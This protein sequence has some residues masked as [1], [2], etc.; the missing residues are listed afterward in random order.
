MTARRCRTHVTLALCFGALGGCTNE[1]SPEQEVRSPLPSL[2]TEQVPAGFPAGTIA[3]RAPGDNALTE[4]RARLG[5]RLFYD[6]G[7]SRTFDVACS[8]CHRQAHAFAE[9]DVVSTGVEGR[10]GPRNAP[11]LINLAW[12]ESFFW[13]GRTPTLEEQAGKPIENPDE[14]DLPIA[15]AV[16]RVAEDPSYVSAFL[17]A[18]DEPPS[19]ASLRKAI[20]SFVRTL[21]SVNSA[22]DRHLRG[23][24]TSFDEAARRG[25]A[26]FLSERGGCF[27]CHPGGMLTNEG[28][29]NNGAYTAGTD[30][31]RQQIT[32][33]SGDTGKFK[34]PGLRNVELTA[35]YMHDGSLPTLEA[36][37]D[38][39]DR[40]GLGD[41]T[42]DPQIE[43]L[44]LTPDEKA[45]LLAFL[46]S[47]TDPEFASDTRFAP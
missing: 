44:S 7:L 6:P 45:D 41:P 8:T 25:E 43:P 24:D 11:A 46:R 40:G 27:H 32:G 36:V 3:E 21:V 33:R 29:F 14:M 23:D 34:V 20:A 17:E 1:G 38:H 5:K 4:S 42:T 9:P 12:S 35:P 13:D 31:G 16:A 28:L 22:Y 2:I 26:V 47:L 18:Y 10:T 30:T 19:E 39:Y 15:D 37:I